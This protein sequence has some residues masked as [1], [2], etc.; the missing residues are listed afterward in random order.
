MTP[1]L[2]GGLPH[3]QFLSHNVHLEIHLRWQQLPHL[4]CRYRQ[5]RNRNFPSPSR[6]SLGNPIA[7][8]SRIATW[9]GRRTA[10]GSRS[11]DTSLRCWRRHKGYH[12]RRRRCR[13]EKENP[14]FSRKYNIFLIENLGF[15]RKYSLENPIFSSK[16]T[17]SSLSPLSCPPS[18]L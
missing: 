9:V 15:S 12:R 2:T 3:L 4:Q 13:Q 5:S 7:T 18:P 11:I 14:R 10:E 16:S 1:S 8:T 17:F 6:F